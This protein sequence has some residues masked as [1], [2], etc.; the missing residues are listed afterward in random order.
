MG[1]QQLQLFTDN[2]LCSIQNVQLW[3]TGLYKCTILC[4][5]IPLQH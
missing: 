5:I 2:R 3:W 1:Q 4:T